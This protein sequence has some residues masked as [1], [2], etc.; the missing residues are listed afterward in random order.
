[1]MGTEKALALQNKDYLMR[2]GAEAYVDARLHPRVPARYINDARDK[3][4]INVIFDKRAKEGHA[5]VYTTRDIKEGEELYA[6]Y[7][8]HY[9]A[10]HDVITA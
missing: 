3:S 6:D 2:L 1:M 10:A 8:S 4:Q 7:G 5:V 9:W